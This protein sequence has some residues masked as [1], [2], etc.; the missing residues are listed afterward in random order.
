MDISKL[1]LQ[2]TIDYTL[3]ADVQT[4]VIQSISGK[5]PKKLIVSGFTINGPFTYT[6]GDQVDG[7]VLTLVDGV[8]VWQPATNGGTGTSGTSGISGSS[9]ISGTSGISGISGSSGISGTSGISGSSGSSGSDGVD[10]VSADQYHWRNGDEI[11]ISSGQIVTI[12]SDYMLIDS[13]LLTEGATNDGF[14]SSVTIAGKTYNRDGKLSVFGDFVVS[15][16][17]ILNNGQIRVEG[18]LIL[19]GNTNIIGNGIII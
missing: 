16:S 15:D 6:L 19:D 1:P 7:Y 13:A 17:D 3:Q 4:G 9:G 5:A 18:G 14:G 8:A 10:G 11:M 2:E 12:G